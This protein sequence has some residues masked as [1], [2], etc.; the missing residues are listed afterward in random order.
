[1]TYSTTDIRLRG[2]SLPQEFLER[3]ERIRRASLSLNRSKK[4][5]S[6]SKTGNS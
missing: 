5:A 3:V 1:M 6:D 2:Q 4:R